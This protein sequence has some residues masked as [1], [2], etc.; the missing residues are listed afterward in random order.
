MF[1]NTRSGWR[2]PAIRA[3]LLLGA[4]ALSAST[5]F[6]AGNAVAGKKLFLQKCQVCH[7]ADASGG[8]K[9]GDTESANLQ[10]PALES[11]YNETDALILRAMLDGKDEDGGDLDKV[12][13]R[14][15][16]KIT[17]AQAQDILAFLKTDI[18][19]TD[20]PIQN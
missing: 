2:P 16:G 19:K 6:A 18:V 17:D 1:G 20:E 7:K 15:R 13:P 10:A 5:A 14:W 12:M 4:F 11:Q 8:I 9:I 3:T